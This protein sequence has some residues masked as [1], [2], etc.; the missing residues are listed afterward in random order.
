[1]SRKTSLLNM[2]LNMKAARSPHIVR[3]GEQLAAAAAL[4]ARAALGE[5]CL[6]VETA[7]VGLV[8][9]R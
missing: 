9:T 4:I 3:L 5:E 2:V 8:A 1:M 7:S 6:A